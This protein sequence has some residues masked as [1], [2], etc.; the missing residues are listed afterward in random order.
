MGTELSLNI[1]SM[2]VFEDDDNVDDRC[3]SDDYQL[4]V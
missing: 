1:C 3:Y 4:V 2:H